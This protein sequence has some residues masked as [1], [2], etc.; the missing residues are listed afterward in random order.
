M[1]W[2]AILNGTIP[3]VHSPRGNPARFTLKWSMVAQ[4]GLNYESKLS[5]FRETSM[6]HLHRRDSKPVK[7]RIP[8]IHLENAAN[9]NSPPQMI[10]VDG[11]RDIEDFNGTVPNVDEPH[12]SEDPHPSFGGRVNGSADRPRA[13][14]PN[15]FGVVSSR[16]GRDERCRELS[17]ED[18][19][20]SDKTIICTQAKHGPSQSPDSRSGMSRCVVHIHH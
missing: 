12:I 1:A 7:L 9:R 16:P 6:P 10:T 18:S 15:N 19:H 8:R 5:R 17:R 13:R 3:G 11:W 2:M 20:F 14:Q 4:V